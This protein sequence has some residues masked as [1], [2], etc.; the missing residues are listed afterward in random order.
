MKNIL[1]DEER[2]LNVRSNMIYNMTKEVVEND[3]DAN[4][5]LFFWLCHE[6]WM[7]K[8]FPKFLTSKKAYEMFYAMYK[9]DIRNFGW[10]D[11]KVEKC[12][13][14]NKK[15][16]FMHEHLT[17]TNDF[18]NELVYLYKKGLL[19]VDKVKDLILQQ[20]ICWITREE[21]D[22]LTH[23][24]TY[25]DHRPNPLLAYKE[26]GIEIYECEKADL[27]NIMIPT[28]DIAKLTKSIDNTL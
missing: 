18:K 23:T 16:Q 19:T 4:K 14:S 15:R 27:S 9:Q 22:I 5:R 2:E 7:L 8:K 24:K 13:N 28:F 21:D 20:R 1:V 12:K 17:T 25:K 3:T 10:A 6:T 11:S 26:C